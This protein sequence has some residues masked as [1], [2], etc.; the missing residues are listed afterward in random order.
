MMAV[1]A[2]RIAET[3]QPLRVIAEELG[4]CDE[5]HF[6]RRFKQIAGVSPAVYRKRLP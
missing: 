1:A 6:S 2:K 5:F 4:F 3:N